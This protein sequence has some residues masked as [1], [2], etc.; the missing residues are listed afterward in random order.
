MFLSA[1]GILEQHQNVVMLYAGWEIVTLLK[2]IS[3]NNLHNR[4]YLLGH[5]ADFNELMARCDIYLSISY[6]WWVNGTICSNQCQTYNCT[7]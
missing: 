1:K 7:H 6:Q 2:F 3:Q 4:I 5:R